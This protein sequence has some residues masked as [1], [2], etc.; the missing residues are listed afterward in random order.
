MIKSLTLKN[1]QAHK[2]LTIDFDKYVTTIVGPTDSGKS[3]ILRALRLLLTNGISGTDYIREGSKKTSLS[4]RVDR[5]TITRTKSSR[6]NSYALDG[7]VFKA[8][9]SGKVP[10]EIENILRVSDI[11]FRD[12][13]DAHFWF[14]LTPGQVSKELNKIVNLDAI[15]ETLKLT[16]SELRQARTETDISRQRVKEY[17]EKK[18]DLV[19]VVELDKDVQELEELYQQSQSPRCDELGYHLQTY[20]KLQVQ[21]DTLQNTSVALGQAVAAGSAAIAAKRRCKRLGKLIKQYKH[22][23]ELG[24]SHHDLKKDFVELSQIRSVA[25]EVAERCRYLDGLI[26]DYNDWEEKKCLWEVEKQKLT[27]ELKKVKGK[28]CPE[29]GQLVFSAETS[30]TL[31]NRRSSGV[32]KKTG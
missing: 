26:R 10:T 21:N 19:W 13:L 7:K 15:D 9:G 25:D 16:A 14:S 18:K 17:R 22:Y 23:E 2:N 28:K 30:T 31:K 3:S 12:Q 1:F 11:N 32:K 24:Q 20:E 5:H 4:A 6:T 29:C 8:F 27:K